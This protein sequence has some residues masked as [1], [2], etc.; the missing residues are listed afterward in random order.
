MTR[1][2]AI[3]PA[4]AVAL[5]LAAGPV[6]AGEDMDCYNDKVDP[7]NRYTSN[8]PDELRVTDADIEKMLADIRAHEMRAS[9]LA[10]SDADKTASD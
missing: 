1:S 3:A 10:Q 4:L 6:A 2:T 8:T 5:V 7:E 9:M